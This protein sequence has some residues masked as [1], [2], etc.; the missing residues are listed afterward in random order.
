MCQGGKET[1]CGLKVGLLSCERAPGS[2][3]L[4]L[5]VAT[6]TLPARMEHRATQHTTTEIRQAG[7]S[8]WATQ[9]KSI[10]ILNILL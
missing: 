6:P 8:H 3:A 1:G 4:N 5:D 2:G 9:L 10:S 7:P